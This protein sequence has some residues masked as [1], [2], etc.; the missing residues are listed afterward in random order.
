MALQ[1]GQTGMS[2]LHFDAGQGVE[3]HRDLQEYA[4]TEGEVSEGR[5]QMDFLLPLHHL[6]IT[7]VTPTINF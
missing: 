6:Q 7:V 5:A 4:A 3:D 2:L 1:S